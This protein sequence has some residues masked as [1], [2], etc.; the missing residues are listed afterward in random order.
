MKISITGRKVNLRD[1]FK[2]L[3]TKK[4]SRFDRIFDEDAQANVVVTLERNRQTVEITIKSRGRIYRAEATDFEMNDALDQVISALGRQIRKNK[5]RLEK[6]IHSTALDQYV[7]DYLHS[8]EEESG[9]YNIVRKKH[10][11]VKPLSVEEAILQMNLLGHQFF[12]FRDEESGEI[13][14][15]YKRKDGNYGLLEPDVE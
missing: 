6:E 1:N 2:E 15:V 7:Q 5:T 8:P 14:V 12:M 10:F 9:E 13:N 4:L 3:A 11:F